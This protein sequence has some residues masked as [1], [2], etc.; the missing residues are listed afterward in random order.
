MRILRNI[1]TNWAKTSRCDAKRIIY[2]QNEAEI[3]TLIKEANQNNT[4][5]KVVGG[6]DSYN[7]I[8]CPKKAEH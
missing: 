7:D 6:G 4:K 8:F 1:Q 5:L 2:P 3:I